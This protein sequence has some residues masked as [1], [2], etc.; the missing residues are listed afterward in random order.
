MHEELLSTQG[1][2]FDWSGY[3]SIALNQE[4]IEIK[5]TFVHSMNKLFE[6]QPSH[7]VNHS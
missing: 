7:Q 4:V 6:Q 2:G 5:I 1:D 3:L